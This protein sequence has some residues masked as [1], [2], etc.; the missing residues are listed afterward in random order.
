MDPTIDIT[1]EKY[2]ISLPE[3]ERKAY[4]VAKEHLGSLFTLEKTAGY[5]QWK[6]K[7]IAKTQNSVK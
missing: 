5:L 3:K 6:N 1:T 4:H 7:Q 2:L